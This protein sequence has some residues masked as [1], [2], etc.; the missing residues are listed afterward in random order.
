MHKMQVLKELFDQI[1]YS[2]TENTCNKHGNHYSNKMFSL[3]AILGQTIY[4]YNQ[5]LQDFPMTT[6]LITSWKKNSE[7]NRYSKEEDEQDSEVDHQC[8]LPSS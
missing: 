8:F 2:N 5:T 7:T 4:K 3:A 1:N 6:S